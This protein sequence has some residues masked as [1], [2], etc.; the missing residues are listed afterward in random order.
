MAMVK[1]LC[2]LG[3]TGSVGQNCLRVVRSL[4]GRFRVE[5]LAA[6]KN[7][8]L[9]AEQVLEFEP[10]VVSVAGLGPAEALRQRLRA[11]GY[12]KPLEIVAGTDG[13]V[14]AATL[15]EVDF[16]VSS[17]HGVTGLRA[18]YEALRAGKQVG[19]ANKEVLVVAGE[20]VMRAA[21][22]QAVEVLPIDSEHSAVHQC[23]RAGRRQEVRRLILTGSGGPL[24][25]TPLADFETVTPE[26]ALKH[27]IWKMGA[28]ITIDSATLMNKG[29]EI[30]EA[31]WLFGL[32]SAQIDV[33]IHPESIVHS[34]IEFQDGAVMA[35][36]SVADMRLPIQYALTYPE[37]VAVDG[38]SLSLDLMAT[39]RLQFERPDSQRFP[40]LRLAREALEKGGAMP[41]ALNAADEVAVEAFLDRR[42]RFVEIPRVI[43]RVMQQT[44]QVHFE[45]LDEVLECDREARRRAA[46]VVASAAR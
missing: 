46:E 44:P 30:I 25:R 35:Q 33:V 20:V 10:R 4:L 39:G 36:L 6:G 7:I 13:Q 15:P 28:R 32:P 26:T 9:L 1:G 8:E 11:R 37:R 29:L 12:Q 19:L 41:C 34:M 27:P 23:L 5:A 40:C 43:E 21:R 42:L 45:T 38:E 2:I 18:T 14:E 31:H 17:S 24:L 16:V 22:E 3:S